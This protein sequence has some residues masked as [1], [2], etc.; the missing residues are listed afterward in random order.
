M[1][2]F[3]VRLYFSFLIHLY[4]KKCTFPTLNN[5]NYYFCWVISRKKCW[6]AFIHEN[7]PRISETIDIEIIANPG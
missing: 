2:E 4:I 1:E 5:L 6:L 7:V 3:S